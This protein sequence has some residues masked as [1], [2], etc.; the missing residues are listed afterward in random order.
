MVETCDLNGRAVALPPHF[1][2]EDQ[3]TLVSAGRRRFVT[4][5]A[6]IVLGQGESFLLPAGLAHASLPEQDGLRCR[7]LYLPPGTIAAP[8]FDA[9]L[10]LWLRGGGCEDEIFAS[11]VG[12]RAGTARAVSARILIHPGENVAAAAART[13]MTREGFSRAFSRQRGLP[14]RLF[15]LVTRLNEAR[16]SLR[17]GEAPAAAAAAAGFADQSHL[18]REFRRVFGVT[19]GRYRTGASQT[20]QTAQG[21]RP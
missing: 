12:R 16:A 4:G 21:A 3:I 17:A 13:G 2:D 5:A 10:S 7:N 8:G 20:F 14:P 1:H 15:G 18:G 9:A 19:P 6:T 11:S